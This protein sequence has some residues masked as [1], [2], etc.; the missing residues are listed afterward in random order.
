MPHHTI[1]SNHSAT[2]FN[3]SFIV[4]QFSHFSFPSL[5]YSLVV[6][7]VLPDVFKQRLRTAPPTLR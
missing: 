7:P 1:H 3:S 5:A 4:L 2:V 6:I